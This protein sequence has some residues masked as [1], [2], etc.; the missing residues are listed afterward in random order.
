METKLKEGTKILTDLETLL[1]KRELK[2]IFKVYENPK[3]K[4]EITS[5]YFDPETSRA[6]WL[7]PEKLGIIKPV[8]LY[9]WEPTDKL[10]IRVKFYLSQDFDSKET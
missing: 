3:L 8:N 7:T 9:M 10:D 6:V 2:F 1:T 4:H 5:E